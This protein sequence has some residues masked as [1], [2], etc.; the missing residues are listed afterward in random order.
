MDTRILRLILAIVLL[1]LPATAAHADKVSLPHWQ[2]TQWYHNGSTLDLDFYNNRYYLNGTSYSFLN[3]F[4]NGAGTFTR[5]DSSTNAT[6]FD[7]TGT[8]QTAASGAVRPNYTYNGSS[9]VYSGDLLEESR[10]NYALN[11]GDPSQSSW[12][13]PQGSVVTSS[14]ATAPDGVS[15]A[16]E[17]VPNT[18]NTLHYIGQDVSSRTQLLST[19]YTCSVY[20][21]PAGYNL[22]QLELYG[23]SYVTSTTTVQFAN[24]WYRAIITGQSPASATGGVPRCILYP[25]VYGGFA[26]DGTS[27]IYV[28]GMQMEVGAFPTSYIPT[29]GSISTRAAESFSVFSRSGSGSA[30]YFDSTGILQVANANAPRRDYDRTTHVSKGLLIEESRTNSI[31]NNTMVG[32]AVSNTTELTTTGTFSGCSGSTCT[33]WTT[34][35][36]GGAGSVSFASNTATLTGDGTNAA[37]IY[38]AIPTVSGYTYT[39]AVTAAQAVTVQM[40]TSAGGTNLGA[41]T[42]TTG[43]SPAYFQFTATTTTSYIQ[44]NNTNATPA[45]VTVV[46]VQSAGAFPTNWAVGTNNG[47]WD[48]V[49]KKV[50][51]IGFVNG[52]DYIDLNFSGTSSSASQN[53][54]IKPE[55]LNV[56][57]ASNSQAWTYS[58]YVALVGGS[59]ANVTSEALG[60]DQY[61]STPAYLSG[62]TTSFTPTSTLTR[63]TSTQ[64]TNNASIAYVRPVMYF[65]FG[66]G[67]VINATIRVVMP[68]LEQG[69]FQTSII[70]TTTAAVTRSR[71]SFAIPTGA[72]WNATTGTFLS[73]SYGQQNSHDTNYGRVIGGD[74]PKAFAG[75]GGNLTSANPWNGSSQYTLAGT[76]TASLTTPVKMAFAW[77][78]NATTATAAMSSAQYNSTAWNGAHSVSSSTYSGDWTT[79][80]LYLG[81]GGISGQNVGG[82]DPLNAGL[83]RVT[84]F[85][86]RMPDAAMADFTR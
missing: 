21:K 70:P 67:A 30:T 78:Q 59:L 82:Y 83:L 68:Q 79:N 31:R 75:F 4:L 18:T 48:N 10:T 12:S 52:M 6:Y 37:S 3:D 43:I 86:I 80:Y 38:Q 44:I 40:G 14:P 42:S 24:G 35:I 54:S 53:F 29:S 45:N 1:V 22:A 57:S 60:I 84:F 50:S 39:L 51:A 69:A 77:D 71:D 46:S 19:Y 55:N 27:G 20:Y 74:Y 41:A 15:P 23:M 73:W 17:Y 2:S 13:A 28:W 26:G 81:S 64:T 36:N 66:N 32:A 16:Y 62:L 85:P 47:S 65:G 61:D 58:A 56:V 33:G 25:N 34:T 72:W 8:L 63:Y 5:S 11:S 76:V 9:W 49:I 7:N